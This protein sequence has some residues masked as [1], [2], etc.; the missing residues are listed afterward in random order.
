MTSELRFYCCVKCKKR[1]KKRNDVQACT[2]IFY[3][4]RRIL[5]ISNSETNKFD[6]FQKNSKVEFNLIAATHKKVE[7][8]AEKHGGTFCA[9]IS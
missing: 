9:E 3:F 8:K 1:N 4:P 5:N 6:L 7:M 2:P